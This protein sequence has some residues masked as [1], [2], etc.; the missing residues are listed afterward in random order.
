[1]Y[2]NLQQT[3]DIADNALN[4]K[5][6][7]EDT[8]TGVPITSQQSLPINSPALKFTYENNPV[9]AVMNSGTVNIEGSKT[10][11]PSR[12]MTIKT[13][14]LLIQDNDGSPAYALFTEENKVD[15]S[16]QIYNDLKEELKNIIKERLSGGNF[17]EFTDKL[18]SLFGGNNRG[19]NN[20]FKG[21][22]VASIGDITA[23]AFK[24]R[25]D[26]Y[27]LVAYRYKKDS[28]EES[29]AIRYYKNGN[30]SSPGKIIS[31]VEGNE[32]IIDDIVEEILSNTQYF[33]SF[34]AIRNQDVINGK[35]N[36][37]LS[38]EW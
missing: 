34:V 1:M 24:G 27:T 33:K 17:D 21:Y 9:I 30:S 23:L 31:K 22:S 37:Y 6:T 12:G 2:V 35:I 3:K 15:K 7:V 20:L 5:I 10:T 8:V 14:G 29:T 13:M 19:F 4:Y 25:K 16:N 32:R 18:A 38:K 28:N 36:K 26:N 11:Y